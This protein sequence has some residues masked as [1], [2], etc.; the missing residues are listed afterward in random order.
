MLSLG[1]Y[2]FII[3]AA[4]FP[5]LSPHF[6]YENF[7]SL[8]ETTYQQHPEHT[9]L[10]CGDYNLPD[11]SWSN[12]SHG[13]T[14]NSSSPLRVPCVPELLA[15][16]GFY[17]K[18]SVLN[19]KGSILD[20]ICCNTDSVIVCESL[21][22]F[23][24][25]DPYHPPL[26]ISLHIIS[27]STT[28]NNSH[29]FH[30]F[31]KADYNCIIH[32]LSSYDWASTLS[33]LDLNTSVNTF[34]DSLHSSILRIFSLLR[35][36]CKYM[37][38]KCHK[39]FVEQSEKS[40]SLNP[41]KFWDFVRR[42]RSHN[43]VPNIV[44]FN[45]VDS[46][47]IQESV[48][49]F[50]KHFSSVYSSK[51]I[52]PNLQSLDLPF[53]DLPNNCYFTPN[54]VLLK[55]NIRSVAK[56]F[57]NPYSR[58]DPLTTNMD[59]YVI[60]Q[61]VFSNEFEVLIKN[62][63][64]IDQEVLKDRC[65]Q[66]LKVLL[67]QFQQRLPKNIHILEKVSLVSVKNALK[68]VKEPL[69]PLMEIFK[70]DVKDMDKVNHQ[71]NNLTNIK[72]IEHVNTTKFWKEVNDYV[73]ASGNN[74]FKDLCQLIRINLNSGVIPTLRSETIDLLPSKRDLRVKRRYYTETA[75]LIP[76]S[77][78]EK[79][80][81]VENY[82]GMNFSDTSLDT[83]ILEELINPNDK[84][85]QCEIGKDIYTNLEENDDL[86]FNLLLES[87]DESCSSDSEADIN[88]SSS[89]K[90]NRLSLTAKS[91]SSITSESEDIGIMADM[92]EVMDKDDSTFIEHISVDPN[93]NKLQQKTATLGKAVGI[94]KAVIDTFEKKRCDG[95]FSV[96]WTNIKGFA[97]KHDISLEVPSRS[98][99]KRNRRE[100]N[101][102]ADFNV[103]TTTA[104]EVENV[105]NSVE[106]YW[107]N[108]IYF[109]ILDAVLNNLKTR[110]SEESMKMAFA[111]D[112]FSL[113]DFEESQYFIY[114]YKDL[115]NI[116]I[117]SLMA[118][119][120]VAQNSLKALNQQ[121]DIEDLKKSVEKHVYPNLYKLL[122]M[123]KTMMLP[124]HSGSKKNQETPHIS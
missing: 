113:L 100:P 52:I 25:P 76:S 73:D 55:L 8:L 121:F 118:E 42:N 49:L 83:D 6:L 103:T 11:I 88:C 23:V 116:E 40:L 106:C 2:K 112:N 29:S 99:S 72:W 62:T 30:N 31:K 54:D 7:M 45:G 33:N 67:K 115:L 28:L 117:K 95:E 5:P 32:F 98:Y 46:S 101:Y 50:S 75:S 24:P 65:L 111:V 26:N 68:V 87:S 47:C 90:N 43:A 10:L 96:L 122:Q 44:S 34:T 14:Y 109:V 91:T 53:F 48:N 20:L 97:D 78:P 86:S 69:T 79:S 4:Y 80:M 71:W 51:S 41:K 57:V 92:Q 18:N 16:N 114:H 27:T 37:S 9:F 89:S 13:L 38:K 61:M 15:F 22:P 74:P 19:S 120:I 70:Y 17:Q 119:M 56:R 58:E 21:E 1:S 59:S 82:D 123:T 93:V 108:H 85:V 60:P 66:F 77:T 35:A 102:L 104:A 64:K 3:N 110:F 39:T 107:R 84:S 63:N 36:K 124:T 105:E 94:I 12:D 81:L